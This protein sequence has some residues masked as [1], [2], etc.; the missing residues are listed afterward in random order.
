M[1]GL[2][3]D[4][5]KYRLSRAKESLEEAEILAKNKHWNSTIGR[6]YY[7]C[8]YVVS[9]LLLKDNINSKTHS[10]IHSQ[11]NL[12]F[13]KTDKVTKEQGKLFTDLMD[14]RV[15][16]EYGDMFDFDEKTVKTLNASS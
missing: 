14:M 2:K 5:I 6:L 16:G 9:S 13:V 12:H 11:F 10:G 15:K 8:F 1:K 4:Y 3:E 7:A